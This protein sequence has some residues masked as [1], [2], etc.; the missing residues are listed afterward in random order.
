MFIIDEED[1]QQDKLDQLQD[2]QIGC[3]TIRIVHRK[4]RTG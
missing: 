3:R 4:K 1:R 2:E